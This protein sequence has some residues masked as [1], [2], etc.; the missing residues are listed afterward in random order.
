MMV[1]YHIIV[2][3]DIMTSIT[4][5]YVSFVADQYAATEGD[6]TDIGIEID[7]EL[8][9]SETIYIMVAPSNNTSSPG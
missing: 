3:V 7:K 9:F 5:T 2:M 6:H 1:L 8:S 4:A